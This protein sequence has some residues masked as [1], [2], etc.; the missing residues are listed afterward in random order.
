MSA[1]C[2][3]IGG[4]SGIG[5]AAATL[6]AGPALH[7][8]ATGETVDV[9]DESQLK[10][11]WDS[12]CG[13]KY[14]VYSAGINCLMPYEELDMDIARDIFEVNVLGL[15]RVIKI[16]SQDKGA[17]KSLVVVTSDA[18]TRPMRTS[19]AY[20][21]SKAA[22][23]ML[24]KQAAREQAGFIKVNG[25]AP[26]MTESTDMSAY[27]DAT[28]P[29]LRGWTEEHA[30]SYERSQ[31]PLQ[32]RGTPREMAEAIRYLLLDSPDY[33]TGSIMEVNGGR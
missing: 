13:F 21:A 32:R 15:M 30:R 10:E 29:Q 2:W 5:K 14:V 16:M 17:L 9:R 11:F 23:N 6:L 3:V 25:I 31:I 26:G 7:V 4:T 24:I 28:V 27:I 33:Q 18:A 19:S 12:R 22:V 8:S 1:K 20:C